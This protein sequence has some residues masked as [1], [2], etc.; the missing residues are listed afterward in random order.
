MDY[1]Q[2]TRIVLF[3][4]VL[5]VLSGCGGHK[6]S[7]PTTASRPTTSDGHT[8]PPTAARTVRVFFL[9]GEQF[10][11]VRRAVA[12]GTSP[13]TSAMK[14]LLA[15]PTDAERRR[16]TTSALPPFVT[17]VSVTVKAALA[18]VRL[19]YAQTPPTAFDVSLRPA[20]AAQIVYTL[21]AIRGIDQVLIR[22]NG[23][24]RARFEGS[25]LAV[26]G[27]LDQHD[28]SKPLTLP[29]VPA[30]VP[31]GSA[32][33]DPA[34]VQRRLASLHYLPADAVTGRWD[35]RT[36]Q[37]VM[38]FQAWQ[39]VGRDGSVGPQTLAALETASAPKPATTGTGKRIEVYRSKGV[40]LLIDGGEVTL[41]VHSSSGA[42]GYETPA[43]TYS[44]FRKER[45]SWSY[46]YQVW[47]PYASYFNG[48]IAFHESADVPA[49]P[50][51]HGCIRLPV[52]EAAFVYEFAA[53]GTP[54]T[55]Y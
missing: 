2:P 53:I 54:V 19:G 7:A 33:A 26:K 25:T 35:Y 31:S 12:A 20:R 32:P 41:A 42:G 48:G 39:G 5:A 22:V 17:L 43:G 55:V 51:S 30:G 40:T 18:T 4:L 46:P 36:S 9:K 50:A 21:T 44:V 28:L 16:G 34:G 49:H 24:D 1:V 27:A 14:S 47:L 52:P 8:Q 10:V 38:A 13:E 6:S 11:A 15:G 3:V 45:N 23:V 29:S 37:A